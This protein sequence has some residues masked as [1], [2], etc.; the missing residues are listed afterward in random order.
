MYPGEMR[1]L[2]SRV[3]VLLTR[4]DRIWPRRTWMGSLGGPTNWNRTSQIFKVVA[5]FP[6]EDALCS[7]MDD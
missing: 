3:H 2:E 6:G 7:F 1:I 4:E 5:K